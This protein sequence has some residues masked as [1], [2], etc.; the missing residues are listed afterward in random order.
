MNQTARGA[1]FAVEKTDESVARYACRLA[2]V[3]AVPLG[4]CST[5]AWIVGVLPAGQLQGIPNWRLGDPLFD[6]M[7]GYA[8]TLVL[9]PLVETALL[10]PLIRLFRKL[11][12][13][14]HLIPVFSGLIWGL[15][16]VN[17]LGMLI[18][19]GAAW[20]F[21]WYTRALMAH[22]KPSLDRAWILVSFIH[23]LT[24][25]IGLSY[26]GLLSLAWPLTG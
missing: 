1:L 19:M 10:I 20:P 6:K 7:M 23:A 2:F 4:V 8:D 22:E 17:Y 13:T 15:L 18:G 14:A 26:G 16:H 3:S 21:Y 24:N 11:G 5:L 12:V 9:T 25:L